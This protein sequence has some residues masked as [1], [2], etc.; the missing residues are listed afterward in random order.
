LAVH[1]PTENAHHASYKKSGNGLWTCNSNIFSLL[2]LLLLRDTIDPVYFF[3]KISISSPPVTH[4]LPKCRQLIHVQ[5]KSFLTHADDMHCI[6]H[7]TQF[8]TL[9]FCS[10]FQVRAWNDLI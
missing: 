8:S 2:Y 1:V 6:G 7:N 9:F 5:Q 10:L 3:T 4:S